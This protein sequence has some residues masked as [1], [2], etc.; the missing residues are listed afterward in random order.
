MS[1]GWSAGDIATAVTLLYNIIE[2]LDDVDG[3][4][5]NYREA[6]GFLRDLKRTLEPLLTLTAWNAYSTYANEIAEQVQ[7]IRGPMEEFLNAAVKYEP[8]LGAKAK[9]GHHRHVWRKLQWYLLKENKVS[10]LKN[11]IGD[12]MLIIDT[13]ICRLIL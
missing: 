11:K 6:M 12:H 2:A 1:F 10:A 9:K 7:H 13:L 3:T 5:S 4:A 8:S